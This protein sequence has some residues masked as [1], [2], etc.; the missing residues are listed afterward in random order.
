MLNGSLSGL[1]A[2][3]AVM[4][5]QT[6]HQ[7]YGATVGVQKG[8]KVYVSAGSG[9]VGMMVTQL[10][11]QKKK[12][13]NVSSGGHN[14]SS[15]ISLGP[16][17]VRRPTWALRTSGGANDIDLAAIDR[18]ILLGRCSLL[19]RYKS[20]GAD[21]ITSTGSDAKVAYLRDELGIEAFNYKTNDILTKLQEFAPDGLQ[22]YFDNVGGE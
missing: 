11:V 12:C 19:A 17:L 10:Y 14:Y 3:T 8:D 2:W 6:R 5:T 9:A 7:D 18:F 16:P 22:Y 4:N 1:T 15:V 21:V 20:M 13:A